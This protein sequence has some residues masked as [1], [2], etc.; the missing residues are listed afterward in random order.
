MRRVQAA[1]ETVA[2]AKAALAAR[3]RQLA[4]ERALDWQHY[5]PRELDGQQLGVVKATL[6]EANRASRNGDQCSIGRKGTRRQRIHQLP[7]H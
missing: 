3:N 2:A 6:A 7:R 5:E 1:T 4:P